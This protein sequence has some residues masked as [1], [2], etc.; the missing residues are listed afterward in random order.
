MIGE[1]GL[2]CMHLTY[3]DIQEK[4]GAEIGERAKLH[5]TPYRSGRGG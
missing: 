2:V 1:K 5:L 3:T 4:K